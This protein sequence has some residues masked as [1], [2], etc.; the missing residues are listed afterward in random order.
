MTIAKEKTTLVTADELLRL[1]SVGIRGKLI[2][3]VFYR[4]RPSEVR[5][6]IVGVNICYL[7]GTFVR[8]RRLGHLVAA[9][10]GV[11]LEWN[12]DTVR[13]VDCAYISYAKWPRGER[14][15]G[16]IQ[17]PPDIVVEVVSSADYPP[18]LNDKARM[19][20]NYGVP[21]VWVVNPGPHTI[22]VHQSDAEVVIL[23]ED[24]ILDGGAVL[25]GFTC[26]VRDVFD[27]QNFYIR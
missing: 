4:I 6:G 9:R 3:G 8:P 12:P 24:D 16:Y 25:P 5:H 20:L 2:R 27:L 17:T 23:D 18:S 15:D 13:E 26:P 11:Q 7:L 14:S 22:E 21:L 10:T 1:D 19:W